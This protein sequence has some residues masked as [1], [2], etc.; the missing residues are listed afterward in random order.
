MLTRWEALDNAVVPATRSAPA[1]ATPAAGRCFR[2]HRIPAAAGTSRACG[3]AGRPPIALAMPAE[4]RPGLRRKRVETRPAQ[5]R[6]L[7]S[8]PPLVPPPVPMEASLR[9]P[10]PPGCLFGCARSYW[11]PRLRQTRSFF[12]PRKRPA[13]IAL[14][15]VFPNTFSSS[16]TSATLRPSSNNRC[17]RTITSPVSTGAELWRGLAS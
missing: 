12:W 8:P 4:R 1:P 10:S 6:A 16:A 2:Y 15:S 9:F 5:T 14:C 3:A 17:A 7:P 11:L 13:W